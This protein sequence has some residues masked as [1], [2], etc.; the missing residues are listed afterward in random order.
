MKVKIFPHK[1]DVVLFLSEVFNPCNNMAI[2]QF[3]TIYFTLW[4]F[5]KLT[6]RQIIT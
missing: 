5:F 2:F 6:M 1:N 3:D 4:T